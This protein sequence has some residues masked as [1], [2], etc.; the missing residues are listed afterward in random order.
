[1]EIGDGRGEGAT[2]CTQSDPALRPAEPHTRMR[3]VAS[4]CRLELSAAASHAA[5]TE[6]ASTRTSW[7]RVASNRRVV[8]S[9]G[10]SPSVADAPCVSTT[11]GPRS[12]VSVYTDSSHSRVI[13]AVARLQ[14]QRSC[15]SRECTSSTIWPPVNDKA[16]GSLAP[17]V[18][19]LHIVAGPPR[20]LFPGLA[21]VVARECK[22][23]RKIFFNLKCTAQHDSTVLLTHRNTHRTQKV[24]NAHQF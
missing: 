18:T 3:S 11:A 7:S 24:R 6:P 22:S 10:F 19:L 15:S 9:A 4:P 17:E 16:A 5:W 12:G 14:H 8:P 21:K 13:V 1:M 23:E 2:L 20:K